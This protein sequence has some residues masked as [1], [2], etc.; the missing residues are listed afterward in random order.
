MVV[1]STGKS[2][3]TGIRVNPTLKKIHVNPE[4]ESTDLSVMEVDMARNPI[5]SDQVLQTPAI[6]ANTEV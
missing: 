4:A 5:N 3:S 6:T 1:E 2:E